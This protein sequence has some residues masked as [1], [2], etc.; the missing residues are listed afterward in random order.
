MQVTWLIEHD[1]FPEETDT[2]LEALD[3]IGVKHKSLPTACYFE[4]SFCDLIPHE[5]CVV[6]YGSLGFAKRFRRKAKWIPGVYYNV[7]A[8]NCTNY[9]AALG[10]YLLNGNYMMLPYGEL[11]RRKEYLFEHLSCDR[12]IF[13]RPNRGD[14]IFTGKVVLKE[15]FEKDVEIF[16]FYDVAPE[17]IV[18]VAEP[19]NIA[20]EWRFVVVENQVVAGSQ[21]KEN[22]IVGVSKEYPLEAFNL[23]NEIAKQ[24]NPDIAWVIDIGLTKSGEYCL[25][26]VGCFSCAGL[27][28][29]DRKVI[30]EEVSKVAWKEWESYQL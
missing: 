21:Y 6:F 3:A 8:F 30:A 15:E 17:E 16:G 13:I 7:E 10:K 24:Y 14:K 22:D 28:G 5:D 2:L 27:Y 4:D 9:Y 12:A 29:C 23:A 26:E 18:V 1:A 20:C 11:I 19:R 25:V